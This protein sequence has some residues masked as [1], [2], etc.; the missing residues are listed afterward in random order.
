MDP[1]ENEEATKLLLR[2]KRQEILL[3]SFKNHINKILKEIRKGE[4]NFLLINQLSQFIVYYYKKNLISLNEDESD[5]DKTEEDNDK[6]EEDNDKTEEDN[7]KTEE[8]NDKTEEDK[9]K[10]EEDKDKTEEDKD[11]TEEDK[12]KTKEN[13]DKTEEDNDKTEESNDDTKE[14]SDDD[15]SIKQNQDTLFNHFMNNSNLKKKSLFNPNYNI[16]EN[17]IIFIRNSLVY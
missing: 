15:K 4:C 13:K 11:K 1:F 5:N 10:T 16:D 8:D 7:D 9:D 2:L 3:E 17:I 14:E 6:T 12:D